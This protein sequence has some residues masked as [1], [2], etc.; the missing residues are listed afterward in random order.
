MAIGFEFA[1]G[2]Q[3]YKDAPVPMGAST[4]P[5]FDKAAKLL[6]TPYF[7]V[8]V[9]GVEVEFV[10]HPIEE[11]AQ[12][13]AEVKKRLLYLNEWVKVLNS[14][15]RKGSIPFSEV[16]SLFP[17][18]MSKPFVLYNCADNIAAMPQVTIGIRLGR[19]RK[20]L[21]ILGDEKTQAAQTLFASNKSFYSG[22]ASKTAVDH[23][24]I[25]DSKWSDHKPSAKL[26]GLA[27]YLAL[28]LQRGVVPFEGTSINAVKYL[29][30]MMSR[31]KFSAL[32]NE[33]P[34]DEQT[35]YRQA[36]NDWVSF[37][38]SDMMKLSLGRAVDSTGRLIE[39]LVDDRRNLQ[40]DQR[41]HIDI[42]RNEWLKG[43]LN[44]Q[45]L[46]SAAAHPLDSDENKQ[47]YEDSNPGL[48]H[49]LRGLAALGD[50]MDTVNYQGAAENTAIVEFRARQAE[51]PYPE[52]QAYGIKMFRFFRE[53]NEGGRHDKIDLEKIAG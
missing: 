5:A 43:M 3:V 6:E 46:F 45:D 8:T 34:L 21:R 42:K 22:L 28:Y 38:C 7:D 11:D 49:R 13:E 25:K 32:F 17:P 27:T 52:W 16:K 40:G 30:F 29:M 31:T 37:I 36:P 9:D 2:W 39:Y 53:I 35:H 41:V 47:K 50:K 19:L 24:R 12:G 4:P 23:S 10:V 14:K 1:I 20:L 33:L 18:N 15:K 51:L 44:G 26:R 48:G